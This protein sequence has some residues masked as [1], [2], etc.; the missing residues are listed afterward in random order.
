MRDERR[1]DVLSVPQHTREVTCEVTHVACENMVTLDVE[2]VGDIE[3]SVE[4]RLAC[5]DQSGAG[6]IGEGPGACEGGGDFSD[7]A[8]DD[9]GCAAPVGSVDRVE[10]LPLIPTAYDARCGVCSNSLLAHKLA[11]AEP[12]DSIS[13]ASP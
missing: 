2:G 1:R 4:N 10:P 7:A 12:G 13:P 6:R 3:P 9:G 8:A 11:G 5:F